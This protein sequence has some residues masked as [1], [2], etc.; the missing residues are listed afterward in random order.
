M[1]RENNFFNVNPIKS[2]RHNP[3]TNSSNM[4]DEPKPLPHRLNGYD[5]TMLNEKTVPFSGENLDIDYQIAEK[6]RTLTGLIGKIKNAELYGTQS[7]V[8]NLKAKRRRIERE[9][10]D[11][12]KQKA[13]M[14]VKIV[15]GEKI[16]FPWIKK[17]QKFLSKNILSKISKKFNSVVF[18]GES[19]EKLS[20]INKNVDELIEMNVPYG[21]KKENY[22]KLT[23]Y[24]YDAN[25]IHSEISKTMGSVK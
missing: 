19:L 23:K 16:E 4:I 8:M 14:S 7:E 17:T 13:E 9:L 6:E 22:E 20:A 3:F 18:L 15:S 1:E 10:Y 12:N 24:L 21:E 11:L 25:R 5:S 2:V